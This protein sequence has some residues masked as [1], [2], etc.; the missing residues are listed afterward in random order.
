M[1]TPV[2]TRTVALPVETWQKMKI[3]AAI[4]GRNNMYDIIRESV[5]REYAKLKLPLQPK[6]TEQ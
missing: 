5:D 3:I 1:A 4:R 6:P 2:K